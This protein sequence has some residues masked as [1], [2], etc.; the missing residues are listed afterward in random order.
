MTQSIS[1]VKRAEA[2]QS[3]Y[4]L[5]PSWKNLYKLGAASLALCGAL[6]FVLFLMGLRMT[7][8]ALG[9]VSSPASSL[10]LI[11]Q[12]Q[13]LYASDA[14]LWIISDFFLIPVAIAAYLVLRPTN[15]S[16]ALIGSA[17]VLLYV[18]FDICVTELNSLTL[19]SLAQG[20]ASS[21]TAALQA[22]YVGAAT[23]GTAAL[24][25]QT[26]FSFG[27][28]A[29]GQLIWSIVM[30]KSFFGRGVAGLGVV[31][32]ILP[33]FGAAASIMPASGLVPILGVAELLALPVGAVWA[34]AVGV[35][36]YRYTRHPAVPEL[37]KT[38]QMLEK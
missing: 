15:R 8:Y 29:V 34:I 13:L 6:G 21:G 28:G 12:H 14:S 2:K 9:I 4:Y 3:R 18:A 1:E 32:N 38:Q 26:V 19:I 25:V 16:A 7:Q 23:Y 24:S 30:W 5:D 33:I 17:L 37:T 22:Q 36:L 27:I 35:K 20:F 10:Q 31:A 11:S